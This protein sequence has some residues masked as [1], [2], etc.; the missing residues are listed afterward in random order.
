MKNN[1]QR[2]QTVSGQISIHDNNNMNISLIFAVYVI[3]DMLIISIWVVGGGGGGVLTQP[4][5]TSIFLTIIFK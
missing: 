3:A 5:S 2:R 1:S 4:K